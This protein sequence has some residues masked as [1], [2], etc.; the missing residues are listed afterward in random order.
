MID[1]PSEKEEEYIKRQEL[2]RLKKLREQAAEETAAAERT[3][4]KEQHWMRCPKCG[5][6]LAE[7]EYST[8]VV[9][10]CFACGGMFLDQGEIEKILDQVAKKETGF[11]D[12]MV[13]GL[14]GK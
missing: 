11:L 13:T 8:V 6:E 9:D 1:K 4:L 7:V 2:E 12:R 10:A 14:F 3:R 5:M